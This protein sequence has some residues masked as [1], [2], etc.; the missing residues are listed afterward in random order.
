ML[1]LLRATHALLGPVHPGREGPPAPGPVQREVAG[2]R[3][4]LQYRTVHGY[5]R[6]FRM[7]GSGPVVL[8][9]HGIGDDSSTWGPNL[10]D[11][12]RDHTVLAPDLLGHGGDSIGAARG[13]CR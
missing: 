10:D 3:R 11:L 8:L 7:A 5:C 1:G 9:I 4:A 13:A 12:A 6:A 2:E